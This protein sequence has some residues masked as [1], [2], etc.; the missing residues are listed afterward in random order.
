MTEARVEL[1]PP[2]DFDKFA[3]SESFVDV[4]EDLIPDSDSAQDQALLVKT[5]AILPKAVA[6]K[7][8]PKKLVLSG[9]KISP[10]VSSRKSSAAAK[11]CLLSSVSKAKCS[12]F[13]FPKPQAEGMA[14]DPF[15]APNLF[16]TFVAPS[17]PS[18]IPSVTLPV[19]SSEM[20]PN[21]M[22]QAE[23]ASL[24]S[25]IAEL[26]AA[27]AASEALRLAPTFTHE[28]EDEIPP[29]IVKY[30]DRGLQT[31]KEVVVKVIENTLPPKPA[32]RQR[33]SYAEV[34]PTSSATADIV[35]S[36]QP[37]LKQVKVSINP[38]GKSSQLSPKQLDK[39]DAPKAP[40]PG[41]Q[42]VHIHGF[43]FGASSPVKVFAPFLEQKYKYPR[44]NV[45]NV[46]PISST[47]A[48]VVIDASSLPLLHSALSVPGSNLTL[49]TTLN[50][51]LPMVT[52][53][54]KETANAAFEKRF[55]REIVRL[56]KLKAPKYLRIAE[57]LSD[58]SACGNRFLESA[59]IPSD[60]MLSAFMLNSTPLS[61]D[62]VEVSPPEFPQA[63]QSLIPSANQ[64][65][66]PAVTMT[67]C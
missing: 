38:A 47:I 66:V 61:Y 31:I 41:M 27:L 43:N 6:M 5:S 48:E 15:S 16:D 63:N 51:R 45:L 44:N 29:S 57:L 2:G 12:K 53:V 54:T 13:A 1:A 14:V 35:M 4:L 3:D 62:M 50:A 52:S 37:P 49:S 67:P 10:R 64:D 56:K 28:N 8:G 60:I 19:P 21:S 65:P 39:F 7:R 22:I 55:S 36:A 25:E 24:K 58:Y 11:A 33:L 46:S 9:E 40:K 23:L 20:D 32:P 30:L 42:I 18:P 26:K 59:A 17:A 34:G